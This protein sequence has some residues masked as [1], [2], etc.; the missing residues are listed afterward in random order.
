MKNLA[1]M[2][3]LLISLPSHATQSAIEPPELDD[4][5]SGMTIDTSMERPVV[6][7]VLP[8]PVYQSITRTDLADMHVFNRDGNAVVHAVCAADVALAPLIGRALLGVFEVT[9]PSMPSSTGTSVDVR[10]AQGT[11]VEINEPSTTDGATA[12]AAYVIDTRSIKED[13]RAIEFEWSSTDGASEARV[14]IQSSEDLDTWQTVVVS[15]TLLQV[16]A[17]DETALRRQ[18]IPLPQRRYIYLRVQRVDGGTALRIDSASAEVVAPAAIIDPVWFN[19]SAIANAP[20]RTLLFASPRLAPVTHARLALPQ[21][22]TSVR[23][24]LQSR[25][26]DKQA[27][28]TQ[29]SGEVYDIMANGERRVSLPAEFQS[30]YDRQWRVMPTGSGDPFYGNATLELGYRPAKLRFLAQ[31]SGPFTLAYGSR[32]AAP[33]VAQSCDRLLADVNS[34]DMA[35]LVVQANALAPRTLGGDL[36]LKPLP[37]KTPTRLLVLWAVLITGVALLVGMARSLFRRLKQPQ[38]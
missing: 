19:A 33:A 31:G 12:I 18:K 22:N 26:D 30:T 17:G 13:I 23:V 27:W 5:A 6:E 32:R 37:A 2:A 36:A 21:A 4:Y 29:W 24:S 28:R 3:M 7:I 25:D 14:Q 15:S 11:Q 8:D 38:L 10:T 16:K 1:W 35:D 9:A 34:K 20:A